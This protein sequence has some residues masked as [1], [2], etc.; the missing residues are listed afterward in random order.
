MKKILYFAYGS[1]MNSKELNEQCNKKG[2]K[3]NLKNPK[4]AKLLGYELK[5]TYFSKMSRKCGVADIVKSK[6]SEVWGVL[7]ETDENS[8]KDLDKKEGVII[9]AYRRISLIVDVENT[10]VT[11]VI[12]YE[13]VNKEQGLKPSKEYLRI[14]IEG[15]KENK[16]PEGYIKDLESINTN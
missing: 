2:Y 14:I 10:P 12:S 4:V 5:F 6:N 15:V 11:D 1:N 3:I 9:K 7:F 13:V 8:L 16:L